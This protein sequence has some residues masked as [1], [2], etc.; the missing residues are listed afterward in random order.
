MTDQ[1]LAIILGSIVVILGLTWVLFSYCNKKFNYGWMDWMIN[2]GILWISTFIIC[3]LPVAITFLSNGHG[4]IH[5]QLWMIVF[6]V[7]SILTV[8]FLN[9]QKTNLIFGLLVTIA[10]LASYIIGVVIYLLASS[11]KNKGE[12]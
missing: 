3:G 12:S 6:G 7:I 5:H 2:Y 9:I 8:L 1:K 10:Q 4:T 11:I